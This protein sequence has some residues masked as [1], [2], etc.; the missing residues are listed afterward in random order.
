M[1]KFI[2]IFIFIS[3]NTVFAQQNEGQ[4]TYERVQHWTKIMNR[5][6]YLSKEEKDRIANTWG[7]DEGYKEKMLLK[8]NANESHY[9]YEKDTG[10]TEDGSWS[11]R[12]SDY[13]IYR[14]FANETK[15]ELMEMLGKTYVVEDSLRYPKWKVMNQIKDIAGY[16]C[17]KAVTEDTVKKQLITAWFCGDIPASVGPERHFGLPGAILELDIN[18]GDAVITATKVELKKMDTSLKI[19]K[20]KG[21]KI[22]D[23]QYTL[24][25]SNHMKD[26]IKSYRNPYWAMRY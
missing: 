24:L 3:V 8:F 6:P 12:N 22:N 11:W 4:I 7:D 2:I 14:N 10:E 26:S 9:S 20:V 15:T 17:M 21:K 23:S 5:L 19:A 13:I 1:R 16:I 25:I 18:E